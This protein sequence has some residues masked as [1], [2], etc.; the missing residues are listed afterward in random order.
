MN[1]EKHAFIL[2]TEDIDDIMVSALE[3][4]ITYWCRE[5]YVPNRVASWAHE[6]IARGGTLVLKTYD[7]EEATLTLENL[8]EGVSAW[9]KMHDPAAVDDYGHIDCCLVDAVAADAIVQY[10]VFGELVYS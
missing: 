7:G 5:A 6:Q 2:T 9:V 10:A 4:G 1:S 8:L 3:G